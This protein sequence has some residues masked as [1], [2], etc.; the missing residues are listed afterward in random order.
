MIR[1]VDLNDTIKF[2]WFK[3]SYG[4]K[5]E[6]YDVKAHYKKEDKFWKDVREYFTT[7]DFLVRVIKNEL[8]STFNEGEIVNLMRDKMPNYIEEQIELR[9]QNDME[10]FEDSCLKIAGSVMGQS[11]SAALQNEREQATDAIGSVLKYYN[12]KVREVP[13]RLRSI[14]E[15][16]EYLLRPHGIMTRQVFLTE[17]WRNNASGAMLTTFADGGKPVA[18]I[19]AGAGYKYADPVSGMMT[20]VAASSEKLFSGEAYA[21]YKAFPTRAMTMK[22]LYRYIFANLDRGRH[23]RLL[24]VCPYRNLCRHA[25]PL[26]QQSFVFGYRCDEECNRTYRDRCISYM[27]I[28]VEF[29]V[30]NNTGTVP[31]QT[32]TE[33]QPEYRV[34]ND[35]EDPYTPEFVLYKVHFRRSCEPR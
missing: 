21:F 26:D 16:L 15:V 7:Q 35:D 19:P 2:E 25:D 33:V 8:T 5:I 4:S 14:D 11:L 9:K 24:R 13:E 20:K 29:I 3:C 6:Y 31:S 10:A 28:T 34:G 30:R 12:I 22:D 23:H 1:I 18:L 17:G 32:D 27:R